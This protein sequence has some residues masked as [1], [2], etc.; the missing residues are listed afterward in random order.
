MINRFFTPEER[1]SLKKVSTPYTT[2]LAQLVIEALD[3]STAVSQDIQ[4]SLRNI[5]AWWVLLCIVARLQGRISPMPYINTVVRYLV[6]LPSL[7]R[8][9]A[10]PFLILISI[11][12]L[13][14]RSNPAADMSLVAIQILTGP[15]RIPR[16]VGSYFGKMHL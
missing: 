14:L 16:L 3:G 4:I 15:S 8:S 9:C 10:L 7:L 13:V 5:S 11:H 1:G 2:N 12:L 6:R